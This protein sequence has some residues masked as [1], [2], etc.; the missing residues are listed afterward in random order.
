VIAHAATALSRGRNCLVLTNWTA[1]L[2]KLTGALRAMGHDPVVLR[3]GM[4]AR[5]RAAALARLQP[6]PGGPPLLA[7]ATD[8]YAGKDSTAP[9]WAVSRGLPRFRWPI[10]GCRRRAPAH[11]PEHQ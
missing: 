3:G 10:A 2:D 5:A 7:V 1:H 9:R 11:R 6:Q 4:G 8:P